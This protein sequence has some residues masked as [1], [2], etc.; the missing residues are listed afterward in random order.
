MNNINDDKV[1]T[2]TNKTA[3]VINRSSIAFKIFSGI[4]LWMFS[5]NHLYAFQTDTLRYGSFGKVTVYKPNAPVNA[6]VLFVSGDGGWNSGVVDMAKNIVAQGAIVAGIDIRLYYKGLKLSTSKCSYPAGDFEELSLMLQKKYKLT[7]YFKPVLIGY[8]SGATLVY[9][10]LAQAP[11]NTFKGAVSLGFCPDIEISKPLCNGSGLKQHV[12]KEG[13]SYYLE[14][15]EK[16]TA[17]FIVLQG[18]IDQV[19]PPGPTQEYMKG[20]KNGQLIVLPK[21]GHG[22]SVPSNWLRQFLSAFKSV[23]EAPSYVEQESQQ[24]LFKSQ[25]SVSSGIG[26]PLILSPSESANDLP[27]VFFIS[28]DGGWT[29]FD[30]SLGKSLVNMGMPVIGLDAQKYFWIA[31]TPG[32]TVAEISSAIVHYMQQWNR[33]NFILAGYSFGADIIPFIVNRLSAS[34]KESLDGIYCFSPDESA[35]FE[36]HIAGM[37]NLR[38]ADPFNVVAE[39]RKITQPEPVCIFGAEEDAKIRNDFS[40]TGAAIVTLPGNHHYNNNPSAAARVISEKQKIQ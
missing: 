1:T 9:G 8:S 26:L 15:S 19:C 12:L 31:K 32:E 18:T 36:I 29:S 3:L 37:L 20:V 11:A 33:K 2:Y 13:V 35:D 7:Q 23:L 24:S 38:E 25:N 6:F 14:A 28:G 22:F 16:L 10:I 27:M 17:P 4:I 21:V 40:E 39:M 34:L 5:L 30:H